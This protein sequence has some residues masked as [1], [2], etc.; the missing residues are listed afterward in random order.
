MK[1]ST[2]N[3]IRA[4]AKVKVVADRCGHDLPIGTIVTVKSVEEETLH[5]YEYSVYLQKNEVALLHL[6]VK[7]D[8]E[9]E[10]N[11]LKEIKSLLQEMLS[12]MKSS[13]TTEVTTK[14]FR[15][16]LVVK[17][18]GSTNLT[19]SEKIVGITKL[20]SD[21]SIDEVFSMPLKIGSRVK[22]VNNLSR[23]NRGL[24]SIF[25]ISNVDSYESKYYVAEN[26]CHFLKEDLVLAGVTFKDVNYK[27]HEVERELTAYQESLDILE[28]YNLQELDAHTLSVAKLVE[29]S[30]SLSEKELSKKVMDFLAINNI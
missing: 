25:T 17:F 22:V 20:L 19:Q 11:K 29:S 13:E 15:T 2:N 10:V 28:K 23:H 14:D 26:S 7:V 24:G 3:K 8:I 27:L 16:Y 4:G 12:W 9:K 6:S 30:A 21:A 18:I 1:R 5:V